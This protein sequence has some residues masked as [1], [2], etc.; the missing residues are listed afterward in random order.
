MLLKSY[1]AHKAST[2]SKCHRCRL[3]AICFIWLRAFPRDLHFS[4]IALVHLAL[5]HFARR[6]TFIRI[7][8][9]LAWHNPQWGCHPFS[10]CTYSLSFSNQQ[11]PRC[12]AITLIK[13]FIRYF[14]R[15]QYRDHTAQTWVDDRLEI[16][17]S[18]STTSS[19]L[20]KKK[21]LFWANALQVVSSNKVIPLQERRS[22]RGERPNWIWRNRRFVSLRTDLIVYDDPFLR[23]ILLPLWLGIFET[24]K[25]IFYRNVPDRSQSVDIQL[26]FW[27]TLNSNSVPSLM[28]RWKLQ[29]L[30]PPILCMEKVL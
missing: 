21:L 8:R 20:E 10:M 9:S 17:L 18:W 16:P 5:R 19:M 11:A 14:L 2:T 3:L 4:F 27:Q 12:L 7:V 28:K 6:S 26:T 1:V 24:V 25:S 22:D 29:N 30:P 15:L 23:S 13:F